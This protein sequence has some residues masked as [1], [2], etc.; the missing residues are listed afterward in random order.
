MR[1][2]SS[3]APN[4]PYHATASSLRS[5]AGRLLLTLACL[6]CDVLPRRGDTTGIQQQAQWLG[7][8]RLAV[9]TD[10]ELTLVRVQAQ[11]LDTTRGGHDVL[12]ARFDFDPTPGLGDEYAITIGLDLGNVRALKRAM[13]YPLGPP[14]ARIPAYGTVACLCRPLKPD[15]VRGTFT[16][17]QRGVVQLV[18]RI[19]A[20]L[21]FTA[22]DDS[23][24]HATYRLRQ[25]IDGLKS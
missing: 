4:P 13:P 3:A 17:S 16:I 10:P 14:P 19:D 2:S 1:D 24:H 15:S 25:R 12:V 11:P 9:D 6:G 21:F 7:A 20:T 8:A 18:A 23:S 5:F 22:W